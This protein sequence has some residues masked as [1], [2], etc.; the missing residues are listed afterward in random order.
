[1]RPTA[2]ALRAF[3]I[4][5]LLAVGVVVVAPA[6]P[7]FANCPPDAAADVTTTDSTVTVSAPIPSKR[8]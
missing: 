5:A 6:A 4:M 2:I 7:A 1:M 3:A 8:T